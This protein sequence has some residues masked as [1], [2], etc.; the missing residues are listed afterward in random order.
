ML[1]KNTKIFI[2]I[3]IITMLYLLS[4]MALDMVGARIQH[5]W[6]YWNLFLAMIPLLTA[7][8]IYILN[9]TKKCHLFFLVCLTLFWVLF[10]PNSCYMITDLIHLEGGRLIANDYTYIR[11]LKQWI[12]LLYVCAGIFIAILSGLFS[13]SLIHQTIKNKIKPFLQYLFLILICFLCGYGVFIGRF[14]RLNSWDILNPISLIHL[15]LDNLDRF[16]IIF[17]LFLAGFFF[18]SYI[19]FDAL[20]SSEKQ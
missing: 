4:G 6:L 19:L 7:Y 13:V 18:F 16:T 5:S 8:L 20:I 3:L 10:L 1:K 14:L 9:I 12:D 17:T 11:N 2:L 15:L